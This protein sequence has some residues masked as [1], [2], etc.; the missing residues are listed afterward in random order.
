MFSVRY[1]MKILEAML[2]GPL[3]A[4]SEGH[5]DEHSGEAGEITPPH[6]VQTTG[7]EPSPQSCPRQGKFLQENTGGDYNEYLGLDSILQ[8]ETHAIHDER[9]FKTTHQTFELW[10]SQILAEIDSVTPLLLAMT[11]AEQT[12]KCLRSMGVVERRLGRISTILKLCCS[13]FELLRTM[14]ALD[15]T[16][17]RAGLGTASGFQSWQFRLVENKLGLDPSARVGMGA[18]YKAAIVCPHLKEK[19]ADSELNVT[20][21]SAVQHWLQVF[22]PALA[23]VSNG[24]WSDVLS[25]IHNTF[26]TDSHFLSLVTPAEKRKGVAYNAF[27]PAALQSALAIT[28]F[29]D[30]PQLQVAHSILS[31]LGDIDA[32]VQSWRFQHLQLV[33]K[34]MGAKRGT[35]G[36]SGY[37]Y[38]HATCSK[39]MMIFQDLTDLSSVLLPTSKLPASFRETNIF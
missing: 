19:V 36:T 22:R 11:S 4:L 7:S 3:W 14:T 35:F 13:Q 31:H 28:M 18:E 12:Q 8:E 30:L 27:S 5:S 37:H 20:L 23:I 2:A 32:Q 16:E 26:G 34:Q 17:F 25:R 9:L 15:F 33:N 1:L 10:F 21:R 29:R 6:G 24:E 39:R 38:L